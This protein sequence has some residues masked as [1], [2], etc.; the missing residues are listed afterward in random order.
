MV[1]SPG[2]EEI[3]AQAVGTASSAPNFRK[4][5]SVKALTPGIIVRKK[6]QV[7]S[8]NQSLPVIV[9]DVLGP[10]T[11]QLLVRI[12]PHEQQVAK[13]AIVRLSKRSS[14]LPSCAPGDLES[15]S[16]SKKTVENDSPRA[17]V[18]NEVS[19]YF[20]LVHFF[21]PLGSTPFFKSS[22][23]TRPLGALLC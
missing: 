22:L 13:T 19:P 12:G 2:D 5:K 14:S 20:P 3:E 10:K 17:F 16:P 9:T 7:G 8:Q 21:L 6:S 4:N 1:G 18:R 15:H 23:T 11:R